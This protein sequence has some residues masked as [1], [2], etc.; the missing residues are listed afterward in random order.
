MVM[1]VSSNIESIN[2]LFSNPGGQKTHE[3]NK[4]PQTRVKSRFMD[5]APWQ[6]LDCRLR[7]EWA[8]AAPDRLS[9]FCLG[10]EIGSTF[11][12]WTNKTVSGGGAATQRCRFEVR[13]KIDAFSGRAFD[14]MSLKSLVEY[15]ILLKSRYDS[16][17]I[18][19][20]Q[21]QIFKQNRG[22]KCCTYRENI[23]GGHGTG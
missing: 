23:S 22:S 14:A 21:E 9:E 12:V 10:D 18:C 3:S 19:S 13:R 6:Y 5:R 1:A 16:S 17:V 2:P 15:S 11:E 7:G 4:S 20:S 8:F